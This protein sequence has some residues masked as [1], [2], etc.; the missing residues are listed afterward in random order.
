MVMS[1]RLIFRF[2]IGYI[3]F[4]AWRTGGLNQKKQLIIYFL[5]SEA[6]DQQIREEKEEKK[7]YLLRKLSF[8]PSVDE[9]KNRK[10]KTTFNS[11]GKKR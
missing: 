9:L 7:R 11:N 6:S 8:R 2:S 5:L 3:N 4:W 10:V 1:R